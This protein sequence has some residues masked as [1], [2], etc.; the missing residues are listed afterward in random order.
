MSSASESPLGKRRKAVLKRLRRAWSQG[1][2]EP[3]DWRD[4]LLGF[5]LWVR[6]VGFLIGVIR[7]PGRAKILALRLTAGLLALE[8]LTLFA[9]SARR[10]HLTQMEVLREMPLP[11]LGAMLVL[12]VVLACWEFRSWYRRRPAAPLVKTVDPMTK[13]RGNQ[14]QINDAEADPGPWP[15]EKE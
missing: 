7:N 13:W 5:W 12:V 6:P 9:Y 14:R 10:P 15:E 2:G 4:S 8:A 3:D 11:S 1:A